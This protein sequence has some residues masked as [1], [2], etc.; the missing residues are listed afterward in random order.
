VP[1]DTAGKYSGTVS[2]MMNMA[3][4]IGG[5]LSPVVFGYLAQDGYWHAQFF[6]AAVLLLL[7]AAI[8]AFWLD[9]DKSVLEAH[10]MPVAVPAAAE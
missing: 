3:G 6:V 10:D 7:G 1:M 5:A 9:P 2:G 4:N 8:W